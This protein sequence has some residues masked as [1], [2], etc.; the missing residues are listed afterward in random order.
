[1][2]D[3][4][5]REYGV[6]SRNSD[7]VPKSYALITNPAVSRKAIAYAILQ[8]FFPPYAELTIDQTFSETQFPTSVSYGSSGGPG[9]KTSIFSVD[10][11]MIHANA[12]WDRLRARYTVDFES[13]PRADIDRVEDFFYAMRGMGIGFRFKD[14]NDYQIGDQN[15]LIGDGTSTSFQMFKRYRSGAD[16]YDRVIKKPIADTVTGMTLDGAALTRNTD[17][18]VNSTTGILTFPTPPDIGAVGRIGYCEFDV[19][20]RFD[21]D[22]ISVTA[23]EFNQYTISSLDL[24]EILI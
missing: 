17:Y 19:P 21:T 23:E 22:T 1:M 15:I 7:V 11:G 13:C 10:S 24:I 8:S 12:E 3:V 14:W 5:S 20:V 9:F 16:I 18:Y 4:F 2:A 6:I